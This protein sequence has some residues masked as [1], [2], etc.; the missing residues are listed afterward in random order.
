MATAKRVRCA[1][2]A[3]AHDL[4]T[5]GGIR[6]EQGR[7]PAQIAARRGAPAGHSIPSE[8]WCCGDQT[9]N[10]SPEGRIGRGIPIAGNVPVG[11]GRC[12]AKGT[13]ME[14]KVATGIL[15]G[16]E[17]SGTADGHA[18][19]R[20]DPSAGLYARRLFSAAVPL[21]GSGQSFRDISSQGPEI[22]TSIGVATVSR[23]RVSAKIVAKNLWMSASIRAH[24]RSIGTWET[25]V[26]RYGRSLTAAT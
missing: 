24:K 11:L 2:A 25:N 8:W 6:L 20:P 17:P 3:L 13:D 14:L 21:A 26:G 22:S 16:A 10:G 9:A 1:I 19:S 23:L 15:R 5:A 4:Q 18:S 7:G 12:P